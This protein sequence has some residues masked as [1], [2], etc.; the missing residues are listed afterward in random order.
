MQDIVATFD[1]NY[2]WRTE[3]MADVPGRWSFRWQHELSG[4]H[5]QSEW[6]VIDVVAR[7]LEPVYDS[8]IRLQEAI[9]SSGAV[10]RSHAM[11]PFEL[12]FMRLE[13]A[14]AAQLAENGASDTKRQEISSI[15]KKLRE[16]L[17]GREVPD[18]FVPE[19]IGSREAPTGN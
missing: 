9:E 5:S 18:E 12:R 6:H 14:L 10:A 19:P 13:R 1:G 15:I 2:S 4:S 7:E 8:L 16:T 17:S 3:V 11:L